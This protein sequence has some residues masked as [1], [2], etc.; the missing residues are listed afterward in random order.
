MKFIGGKFILEAQH[1]STY[2][3]KKKLTE[4]I[5]NHFKNIK[6]KPEN[7][8]DYLLHEVRG[9]NT[10]RQFIHFVI[11]TLGWLQSVRGCC[12]AQPPSQ[13][14]P[15]SAPDLHE[16]SPVEQHLD[17]HHPLQFRYLSPLLQPE[18]HSFLRQGDPRL[19]A[20]AWPGLAGHPR[21]LGSHPTSLLRTHSWSVL[22]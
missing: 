14:I 11:H 13:R 3:K 6:L 16:T 10:R 8:S 18:L 17:E 9:W 2:K 21:L 20:Q 7:F 1:F 19:H 12:S 15:A 4:T 22:R 5:F